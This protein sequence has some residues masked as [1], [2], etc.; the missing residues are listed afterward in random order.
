LKT[1]HQ[2]LDA[3]WW[4]VDTKRIEGVELDPRSHHALLSD[5]A[6]HRDGS[7]TEQEGR[8]RDKRITVRTAPL[9]GLGETPTYAQ[10]IDAAVTVPDEVLVCLRMRRKDNGR[11]YYVDDPDNTAPWKT[12]GVPDGG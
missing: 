4:S 10:F 7:V 8:W 12:Q 9:F 5:P 2:R 11:L 3:L 1:V 6:A